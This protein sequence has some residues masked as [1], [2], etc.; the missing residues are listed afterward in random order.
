LPMA[1][2]VSP[3]DVDAILLIIRRP[4]RVAC[5]QMDVEPASIDAT[6]NRRYLNWIS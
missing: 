3:V 2:F 5:G 4:S 6:A 1:L